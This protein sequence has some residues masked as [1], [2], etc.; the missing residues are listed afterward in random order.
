MLAVTAERTGLRVG[1]HNSAR[2]TASGGTAE[3]RWC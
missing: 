3:R 1:G 2:G